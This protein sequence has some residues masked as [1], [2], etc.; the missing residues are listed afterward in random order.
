MEEISRKDCA[1]DLE[2]RHNV[3][4]GERSWG[5]QCHRFQSLDVGGDFKR[6]PGEICTR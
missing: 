1:N 4:Q 6:F 5:H 3:G 2:R